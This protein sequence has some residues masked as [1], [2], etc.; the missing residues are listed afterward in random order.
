MN[1]VLFALAVSVYI[2]GVDPVSAATGTTVYATGNCY[3]FLTEAG[4]TLFERS[5]GQ[6]AKNDQKVK[7][8]L[9]EFGYQELSDEQGNELLVGWVQNYGVKDEAEVKAFKKSCR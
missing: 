6:E 1:R 9:H 8:E 3:I 5:G 2:L 7:G 4:H